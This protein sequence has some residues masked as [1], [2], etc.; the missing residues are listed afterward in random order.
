MYCYLKTTHSIFL[1]TCFHFLGV[2]CLNEQDTSY[3]VKVKYRAII[4]SEDDFRHLLDGV[5][6]NDRVNQHLD[7]SDDEFQHL[8]TV[9]S[10]NHQQKSH[11]LKKF[12][13]QDGENDPGMKAWRGRKELEEGGVK[14]GK[15]GKD[16]IRGPERR[17]PGLQAWRGKRNMMEMV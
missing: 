15:N 12:M 9:R 7:I 16:A 5:S 13:F 3:D 8:R 17:H 1:F 4:L 14:S 2:L 11:S 10:Q 6:T